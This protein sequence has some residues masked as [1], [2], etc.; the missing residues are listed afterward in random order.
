MSP[1]ENLSISQ[2]ALSILISGDE[3]TEEPKLLNAVA[4]EAF[5]QDDLGLGVFG[6]MESGFKIAGG[7]NVAFIGCGTKSKFARNSFGS[8]SMHVDQ[9]DG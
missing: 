3:A 7:L 9:L 4:G 8:N 6:K 2:M 5:K 1:S